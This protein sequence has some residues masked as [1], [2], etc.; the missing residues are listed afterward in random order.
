M[1]RLYRFKPLE[2]IVALT[3][4]AKNILAKEKAKQVAVRFK[5]VKCVINDIEI[6]YHLQDFRMRKI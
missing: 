6:R 2:G 3:G 5:K 4:T 1:Y